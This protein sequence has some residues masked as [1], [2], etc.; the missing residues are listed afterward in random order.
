MNVSSII[1]KTVPKYLDEV[2]QSVKDCEVCDYHMNDEKG[3]VIIT[4]E[5]ENVSQELEKLHVI[6]AM[7][8][9]IAAD[10][11]MS[12]SQDEL[13]AHMKVIDDGEVVPKILNEKDID[14]SDV[15]YNGDLKKKDLIGFAKTFDN[16]KR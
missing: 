3:N 8:H 11:H 10:M 9:V 1:V 14:P 7:P 2:I 5:G 16:T 13:E 15:V 4:I 6:E 12:Y